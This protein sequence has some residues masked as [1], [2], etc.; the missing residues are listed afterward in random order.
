MCVC[1]LPPQERELQ[2]AVQSSNVEALKAEVEELQREKTELDRTQRQ[3]DQEMQILNTH[4]TART[5]MDMLKKDKVRV[6]SEEGPLRSETMRETHTALLHLFSCVIFS[7]LQMKPEKASS[8]SLV[9]SSLC[10]TSLVSSAYPR[11]TLSL[12][13]LPD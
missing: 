6:T 13:V 9:L 11:T 2:S 1:V 10:S 12:S 7:F 3:L 5:Q 8:S 4:T